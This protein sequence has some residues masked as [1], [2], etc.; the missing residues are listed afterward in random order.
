[1]SFNYTVKKDK[2][3]LL[4]EI[5]FYPDCSSELKF[6][7]YVQ[8]SELILYPDRI[9]D[10]VKIKIPKENIPEDKQVGI[11]VNDNFYNLLLEV[12]KKTRKKKVVEEVEE[13][14]EEEYKCP[15][16]GSVN[17]IQDYG[18]LTEGEIVCGDCGR[19]IGREI[20]YGPEWRAFDD[21]QRKK[22]TR[23]GAPITFSIH[24][25]GL[26]TIIDPRD[27]DH[28]GKKLDEKQK[29]LFYRLRKWQKRIRISDGKERSMSYALS[30]IHRISEI[31]G[32][33]AEDASV[34]FRKATK[35]G[36]IRGRTIEN[37]AAA[38]VYLAK[39]SRGIPVTLDDVASKAVGEDYAEIKKARKAIAKN[40]R[41]LQKRGIIKD[42]KILK[43]ED[44]V[45]YFIEKLPVKNRKFVEESSIKTLR[46][47]RENLKLKKL[48][49]RDPRSPAA[50]LIYIYDKISDGYLT[51]RDISEISGLT[52][53]TIRNRYK[54]LLE[55]LE[56]A[57][58]I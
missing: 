46:K 8:F 14:V 11:K 35:K 18:L 28:F 37:V 39:R 43:P 2:N 44:Y 30:D 26:T 32:S 36:I 40:V 41:E 42:L 57:V 19:V 58:Y 13:K 24:D 29:E 25:K 54:E 4:L 3:N 16:C 12:K 17:I 49:F 7:D 15:E 52:E 5:C 38:T 9:T 34:L 31:S 23:V 47:M 56:I 53:V 45:T 6:L 20:N 48:L 50:A 33:V 51:Q 22:R 27:R 10:N 55:N 1:M 21:E